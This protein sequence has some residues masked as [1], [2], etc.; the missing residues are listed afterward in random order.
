MSIKS[1]NFLNFLKYII[2]LNVIG[3]VVGRIV[4]N[5]VAHLFVEIILFLFFYYIDEYRIKVKQIDMVLWDLG[6]KTFKIKS[7]L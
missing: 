5:N 2:T 1:K 3:I 7:W 4:R 6:I